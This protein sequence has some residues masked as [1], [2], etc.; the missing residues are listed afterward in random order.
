MTPSTDAG[1]QLT[2]DVTPH[3]DL[4]ER[5]ADG[6]PVYLEGTLKLAGDV[7][8]KRDFNDG[9]RLHVRVSDADGNLVASYEAEVE[10]PRFKPIVEK[11]RRLGTTRVHTA[12]AVDA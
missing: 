9:D 4:A 10:L 5:E 2:L 1:A 11:G 3:P 12:R 8:V 6:R 7:T